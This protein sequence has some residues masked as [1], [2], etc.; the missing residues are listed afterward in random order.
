M[1]LINEMEINTDA[2]PSTGSTRYF[3]VTGDDGAKFMI[4]VVTS[5]GVFYNFVTKK[6]TAEEGF[7]SNHN[8]I[9]TL[10]GEYNSSIHFPSNATTTY[11]ILLITNGF[12]TTIRN[13]TRKVSVK[14]ITQSSQTTVT[15]AFSTDNTD[16]YNST[17][18]AA[19][20]L[21]SGTPGVFSNVEVTNA[22]TVTNA[23]N[24]THGSGFTPLRFDRDGV[25]TFS[26]DSIWY[27]QK[28]AVVSSDSS[29][30]I[31]SLDTVEG[32]AVGS[33]ITYVT[34][35]TPPDFTTVVK[36]IDTISNTLTL[37]RAQAFTS[38]N[39]VTIRS[40]GSSL[41]NQ[42]SGANF[43]F[44]SVNGVVSKLTYLG[45]TTRGITDGSNTINLNGSRGLGKGA[46][47]AASGLNRS[48]SGDTIRS[49]VLSENEG[50]I[51]VG[52]GDAGTTGDLQYLSDNIKITTNSINSLDINY[53]L[54]IVSYPSSDVTINLNLDKILIPQAIS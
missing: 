35:T 2:I 31:L 23:D 19:S 9:V 39:T 13:N 52:D 37:S 29:S 7:N 26:G 20:V 44:G 38:G 5:E 47:I 25:I 16:K 46:Q 11:S 34:G 27:Y 12:D 21:S 17:P 50:S 32:I 33:E 54:T 14:K 22:S 3:K 49:V 24:D 18:A 48:N 42:T 45:Y 40:Y 28:T 15:L 51:V 53:F 1:A 4:Q 10:S 41:I 8:Q 6:F 43:K 30:T 36:A